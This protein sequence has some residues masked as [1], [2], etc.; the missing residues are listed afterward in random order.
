ML[1]VY[2]AQHPA[3]AHLV[4]GILESY[5]IGCQIRGEHLWSSRGMVP[6]T[7]E[8][9]P[10]VWVKDD[11]DFDAAKKRIGEYE[12]RIQSAD[13]DSENWRCQWCGEESEGQFTECWNCGRS[14]LPDP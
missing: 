1:Q 6:I 2:V 14:R 11:A 12:A 10:S 13:T 8:T 5:G 4:K 3:E 7:T 9:A